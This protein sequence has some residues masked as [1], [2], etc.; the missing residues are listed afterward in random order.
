M[1]EYVCT[2]HLYESIN[3]LSYVAPKR[4]S[5]T[6]RLILLKFTYVRQPDCYILSLFVMQGFVNLRYNLTESIH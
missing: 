1:L 6:F 4:F 3:V 5:N 2:Q